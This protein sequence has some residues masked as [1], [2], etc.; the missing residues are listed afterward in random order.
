MPEE[1][2]ANGAPPSERLVRESLQ[3][4]EQSFRGILAW[5][6]FDYL[7]DGLLKPLA[8]RLHA[9]LERG[10]VCLG[11][12]AS[13]LLS[14]GFVRYRVV[15]RHLVELMPGTLPLVRRRAFQNRE[16]LHLFSSFRYSRTFIGRDHLRELLLIK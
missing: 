13:R 1:D 7:P 6:L 3:Y 4:P 2:G 5:D 9:L 16:L 11:L 14:H 10:G 12:F 8:A 15:D